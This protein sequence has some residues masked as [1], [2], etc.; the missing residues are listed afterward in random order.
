M[1]R[2]GFAALRAVIVGLH[3]IGV[4]LALAG[5]VGAG[6]AVTAYTLGLRHAFDADH[7]A[8]IDGTTRKLLADGR[9]S[10]SVGFFF[11]LG[12]SS[13]VLGA[14]L[15]LAAGGHAVAAPLGG[16]VGVVVSGTFLLLIGVLN[17]SVLAEALRG[18]R[19]GA[20]AR[21]GGL[22]TRLYGRA[23]RAV[24]HPWQM[25]PLGVLFGLGFDTATEIALLVAAT[26]AVTSGLP[27]TA[28]LCLPVLFAAGMTLL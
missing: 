24:R 25:Y 5:T 20:P 8:A 12:H 11:A 10:P 19:D 4:A 28:V 15:L 1:H 3:A 22:L 7:I 13:V 16:D 14:A 6:L 18:L 27:L 9:P 2:L 21:P 26:G 23:T 17:A